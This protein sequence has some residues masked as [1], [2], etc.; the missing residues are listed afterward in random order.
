M[1]DSPV[2]QHGALT[3]LD[4]SAHLAERI[5]IGYLAQFKART[6]EAYEIDLRLWGRWLGDHDLDPL[7]IERPHLELWIRHM[8]E[9]GLAPAT[10]GRRVGTVRG[11]YRYAVEE[12]HLETDPGRKVK[13]PKIFLREDLCYLDRWDLAELVR[14]ATDHPRPDALALVTI[15]GYN[16]LR[17]SEVIGLDVGDYGRTGGFDTLT[18][19]RKGGKPAVVP[20]AA[21]TCRA[22]ERA[23]DGRTAGPILRNHAGRRMTRRNA[24]DLIDQLVGQTGITKHV[25]PHTFRRSFV[26]IGLDAGVSITDMA[27]SAG[28]EQVATTLRYDRRRNELA[29]NGTHVVAQQIASA[30]RS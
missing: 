5:S 23:I 24:H 1:H 2:R 6:R 11:W 12:G 28:H 13:P 9:R 3:L 26:S 29:R 16:G 15:L 27:M 4:P 14:V 18:F 25:T 22:I 17:I 7:T 19:T 10:I 8:E 20:L 30:M 21:D